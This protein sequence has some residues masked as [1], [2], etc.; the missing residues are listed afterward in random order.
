MPSYGFHLNITGYEPETTEITVDAY[1][2]DGQSSN[3]F[4]MVGTPGDPVTV[5]LGPITLNGP[6]NV[7][8]TIRS[9]DSGNTLGVKTIGPYVASE[10]GILP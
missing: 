4:G 10:A 5:F 7:W 2:S 9:I 3:D 1:F 8:F 6:E